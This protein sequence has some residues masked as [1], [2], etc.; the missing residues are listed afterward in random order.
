MK[1]IFL[2]PAMIICTVT[3]FLFT[4]YSLNKQK[5]AS[6]VSGVI[7][8]LLGVIY[9]TVQTQYIVNKLPKKLND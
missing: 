6:L 9:S 3:H 1:S 5:K 7:L 4:R 2:I 8:T